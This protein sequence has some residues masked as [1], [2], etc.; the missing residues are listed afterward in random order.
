MLAAVS[1]GQRATQPEFRPV[2]S[3]AD[4]ATEPKQLAGWLLQLGRNKQCMLSPSKDLA[5]KCHA[6]FTHKNAICSRAAQNMATV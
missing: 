4:G 1:N 5:A 3:A 2:V 6:S